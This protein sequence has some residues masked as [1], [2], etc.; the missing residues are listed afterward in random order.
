[1]SILGPTLSRVSPIILEYTKL[2][3]EKEIISKVSG[4]EVYHTN[5]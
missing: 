4:N 5:S 3:Y 2:L 1:M